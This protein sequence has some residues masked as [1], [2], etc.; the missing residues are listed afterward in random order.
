MTRTS[1]STRRTLLAAALGSA[2]LP[3]SAAA[4]TRGGLVPNAPEDQTERLE[5]ALGASV[6]SGQPLV[7]APGRYRIA[8]ARLPD[9]AVLTGP[10][11]SVLVQA[12]AEPLLAASRAASITLGGFSVAG[13]PGRAGPLCAFDD[14]ADLQVAG[15]ALAGAGG[16]ALRLERCGGRIATC[17]VR[18]S[19]AAVFSLDATG[20]AIADN[21]IADCRNNAIQVWR[22]AKGHDGTQVSGNRIRAIA[23]VAGGSGEYGN[24][25][26]IFRAG[27]VIVSGNAIRTCAFTA[28]RNNGGDGVQIVQNHCTDCGEV[29]IFSEFVFEGAVIANNV[30]DGAASGIVSTNFKESGRLAAIS[31]NL[32]RRLFRRP[33]PLTGMITYGV[34]ILAEADAAVTGNVVEGAPARGLQL[35][36]GPHL[37]DVSATGNVLRD[38]VVGIGLTVVPGAGKAQIAANLISGAREGAIVGFTWEKAVT[39]DLTRAGAERFEHLALG[40]NTVT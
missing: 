9:G 11:T 8:G 30:V 1:Q 21:D 18:D 6:K 31:G 14:V 36:Y 20:L 22:S 39:G 10:R 33:D 32:I 17:R 28:V 29:A 2:A 23:A 38:C 12:G 37:R 16:P 34:G 19:D 35:G 26:S 27:G 7:L 40:Q 4:A 13:E 5:R 24:G 3:G 15:L 25:V